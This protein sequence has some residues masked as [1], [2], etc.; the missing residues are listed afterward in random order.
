MSCDWLLILE[1]E[2]EFVVTGRANIGTPK[3]SLC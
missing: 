3:F 2:A 1:R